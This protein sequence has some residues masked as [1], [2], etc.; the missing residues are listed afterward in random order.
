MFA[1]IE[2]NGKTYWL[3][4]HAADRAQDMGVPLALLPV[5][6]STGTTH[7]A[8]P[9]SKYAG[10]YVVRA[11]KVAVAVSPDPEGPVISTVLWSTL[12]AWRAADQKAGRTYKGDEYTRKVLTSWFGAEA[13]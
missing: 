4:H 10:C 8:P 2:A 13:A 1:P 11:G 6:L 9:T 3:S 5:I 12:D 7:D